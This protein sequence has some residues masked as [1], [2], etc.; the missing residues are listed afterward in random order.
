VRI[1]IDTA[2][3]R[4]ATMVEKRKKIIYLITKSSWGGAGRYVFDLA[5]TASNEYSVIVVTGEGG[6]LGARL[7][8]AGITTI[9]EDKLGRDVA[10]IRDLAAFLSIYFILRKEKPDILHTNSSKAGVTGVLAG[11]VYNLTAKNKVKIIFTAHGW[12]FN[13]D[14]ATH[15]RLFFKFLQWLTVFLSTKTIAVSEKTARDIGKYLSKKIAVI[16]NGIGSDQASNRDDARKKLLALTRAINPIE[17]NQPV[18]GTV[19]ELHKNKG[20]DIALF[21]LKE[22][23]KSGLAEYVVIG[24]GEERA[25]LKNLSE[26]LGISHGVTFLGFQREASELMAGFD[27]FLLPSR[28]EALP[29]VLLEAGLKKCSVIASDVGGI[30]E[31]ISAG[32]SGLIFRKGDVANLA[33][34]VSEL[35]QNPDKRQR[36]GAGLNE[37]VLTTFSLE[38]MWRETNK[39]YVAQETKGGI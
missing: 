7:H 32:F 8:T 16:H 22:I 13:E 21:G 24:Q 14:R 19:A 35:L 12:A 6:E 26:T 10:I 15:T 25:K 3:W 9:H 30:P 29:Y 20:I 37:K 23:I 39:I 31:I 38:N 4:T 17:R 5:V 28:T 34:S 2:Q 33:S 36:L 18:I 11:R 1:I 27:I